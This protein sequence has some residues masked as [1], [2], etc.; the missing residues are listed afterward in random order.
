MSNVE[1]VHL[2]AFVKLLKAANAFERIQNLDGL[3]Y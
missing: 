1:C 3:G 2:N